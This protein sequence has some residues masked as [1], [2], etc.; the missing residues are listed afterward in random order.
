ME[1]LITA[2]NKKFAANDGQRKILALDGGGI[3]SVLTLEILKEMDTRLAKELK[4]GD[5][6]DFIGGTSTG[7]IIA[8]GLATG[9]K[10]DTLLGFYQEKGE[11]MFK[12][13]IFRKPWYTYKH[14]PLE[15]ELKETFGE[16]D[17]DIES[18]Q[19][20]SLLLAVTMNRTTDSPWPICN[21]PWMKYND[22]KRSDCNLRIPLYK[23]VRA[24]TAAP[25]YFKE[26]KIMVNPNDEKRG[27]D[28]VDGG[29]TPYHNPAFLMYRMATQE[30]YK[31]EWKTSEKKLL[32]VSVGTRSADSPKAYHNLFSTAL[33][34]PGSLMYAMQAD[35]D[36]NCRTVGRCVFGAEID[37]ELMNMI[38]RK[39]DGSP[40]SPEKDTGKNFSYIRYN[41]DLSTKGLLELGFPDYKSRE[42]REMDKVKNIEKLRYIGKATARIQLNV[43]DHFVNFL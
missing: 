42:I 3:R 25:T 22:S 40:E 30:A 39:Q 1:K 20:K 31:L 18:G 27:F 2:A 35:Q 15:K 10:V 5:Y 13:T 32:I 6:F 7:S 23:L 38:P 21:I 12:K 29:V 33:K 34:I 24:S 14:I 9:M 17:I 19:F 28:F 41:A 36:I 11:A 16:G 37:R 43:K 8:A 4:R 26:E